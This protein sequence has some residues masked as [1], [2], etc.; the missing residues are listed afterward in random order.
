MLRP[1]SVLEKAFAL[2]F[3]LHCQAVRTDVRVM[4]AGNDTIVARV[5]VTDCTKEFVGHSLSSWGAL[6]PQAVT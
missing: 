4:P 1:F 2:Q 5:T 6:C 3:G